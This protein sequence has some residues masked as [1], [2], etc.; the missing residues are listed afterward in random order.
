MLFGFVTCCV[1]GCGQD[2]NKLV[3]LVDEGSDD[4]VRI[5]ESG[6]HDQF[7]LGACFAHFF[8]RNLHFVDEVCGTFC[9]M[10]FF[11]VGV[12]CRFVVF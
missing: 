5:E 10:C 1:C 12:V 6:F 9:V 3:G 11:I 7:Q 4:I 2:G 8:E